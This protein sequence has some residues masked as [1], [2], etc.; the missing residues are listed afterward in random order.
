M[1]IKIILVL[2]C[3][4]MPVS[5]FSGKQAADKLV[6]E[7]N[8]ITE[9][10]VKQSLQKKSLTLYDTFVLAVKKNENLGIEGENSL[11]AGARRDQAF[12]AFLPKLSLKAV[13]LYPEDTVGS[14]KTGLN[15]VARQNIFTGL[16]EFA[17]FRS[18]RYEMEMRKYRLYYFSG[19]LL[20][21]T[22]QGFY[23]VLQLEKSL[24][25]REEILKLYRGIV[26]ELRRR[27]AV[28]KTRTSELLRTDA[29]IQKLEAD[30]LSLKNELNRARLSLSTLSGINVDAVLEEN[31]FT[32]PRDLQMDQ[33]IPALKHRSDINA[34]E[35]ELLMARQDLLQARG[36]HLPSAYIEGT[37][38]LY[39]TEP[40][41]DDY[42]AALGVELP[43]FNGGIT[44]ARV[45]EYESRLRQAEL[46]L[47]RSRRVARQELID[48][49]TSWKS[50]E[51][52]IEAFK[53]A[54]RR[55]QQNHYT[56]LR[57]YRLNLAT[58]LD[59]FS[60]L[61]E[62]ENASDDYERIRLQHSLN[63]LRL[64]V[65]VNEFEGKKIKVLKGSIPVS[66]EMRR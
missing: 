35:K 37:Y 44:R 8:G 56:V 50:S 64:G 29:H 22:A 11:Q 53:E 4:V 32:L 25:N 39:Q 58:I 43:L 2:F 45:R 57:E 60:T 38:R 65:A 6:F 54:K 48:A 30:I 40:K 62:L 36:A 18:S 63:R 16:D 66:D 55:A 49:Y 31:T 61:T 41:T 23:S 42:Y 13:K 9:D 24:Q 27:V 14:Q 17:R 1:R 3:L 15:L 34:A 52:E 26:N 33:L 47:A 59:V 10:D 19:Q 46:R 21:E 51:K 12:G 20:L 28:G 5:G 7:V